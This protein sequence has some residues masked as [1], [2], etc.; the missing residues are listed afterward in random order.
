MSLR[1]KLKSRKALAAIAIGAVLGVPAITVPLTV[2]A[3]AASAP[4]SKYQDLSKEQLE[5]AK[6]I[7]ATT[8][9]H[10]FSE[11]AMEIAIATAMQESTLRNL[12]YGDRDSQGLFQQRPVSGWGTVKEIR[13]PVLATE[14][15]LGVAKHTN[16]P[17]LK[18]IKGW[19]KMPLT[20]AAQAVQRSGYPDAYAK[21]EP[22]AKEIVARNKPK[23]SPKPTKT[24]SKPTKTPTAKPTKTPTGKPTATKSP[25]GKPTATKSPIGKPTAKPTETGKPTAKPTET[26]KPT[27]KPTETG[28]PTAKPTPTGKPTDKPT[29]TA[30]PRE[31]PTVAPP[32]LQPPVTTPPVTQ[33][34]AEPPV[35]EPPVDE[36]TTAPLP[37]SDGGLGGYPD[38]EPVGDSKDPGGS[39]TAGDAPLEP[40]STGGLAS[41]GS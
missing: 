3:T 15:F 6:I 40:E 31:T 38:A 39:A 7:I 26:G 34:P 35:A 14:A 23:P 29:R 22:L 28:R 17:G 16:N 1:T 24:T 5:N 9:K 30:T 18:D 41:T 12:N 4:S 2:T 11:R 13:N 32:T 8:K 37:P 10:G 36:P 19:E 20:K 33:P 25:T 21:W 27:A